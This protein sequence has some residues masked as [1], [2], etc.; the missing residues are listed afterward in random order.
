MPP[1]TL[2]LPA[3]FAAKH[4]PLPQAPLLPLPPGHHHLHRHHC[5]QTCRRS[6]PKKEATAAA[7]PAYQR[8][9]QCDIVYKSRR[10][11]LFNLSTVKKHSTS[12]PTWDFY[13]YLAA[14][15]RFFSVSVRIRKSL[16]GPGKSSTWIF[17][18]GPDNFLRMHGK[19]W[20]FCNVYPS[21]EPTK[22]IFPNTN[23]QKNNRKQKNL[24]N[25]LPDI[26]VFVSELKKSQPYVFL[27]FRECSNT[28]SLVT[29]EKDPANFPGRKNS[30][31]L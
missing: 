17:F 18:P 8:Q 14:K 2:L 30:L 21:P 27:C 19:K 23:T 28:T 16:S 29:I 20:S 25:R 4:R 9:H 3:A 22:T 7:P 12:T 1:S 15:K 5:G 11:D 31:R 26:R 24:R 10:L 6:L 13:E